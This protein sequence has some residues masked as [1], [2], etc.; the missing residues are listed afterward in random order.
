MKM[1]D[2][3]IFGTGRSSKIV[4]SGLNDSVDIICYLDNDSSKWG[5]LY[6]SK[7]IL[8]PIKITD[9]TYDYIVIASQFN[10][11]IYNQLLELGV[12]K[13]R[14]LQFYKYCATFFNP[15][16]YKLLCLHQN[17]E[18]VE[19]IATGIS[20][21]VVAINDVFLC[22][23][24]INIAN[25]S[26]DLYYD[27]NLIKYIINKYKNNYKKLNYVFIGLSYYSF[28]YD[29]SLSSMKGNALS[30]YKI[31]GEK[32]NFKDADL[33]VEEENNQKNIGNKIFKMDS[34]NIPIFD[35]KCEIPNS[36]MSIN[37]EIGKKQAR[38]DG[39][40]D[41]PKTVKENIKIFIEYLKL[42]KEN[43]IKPIVIVCPV[44]QYYSKCFSQKLKDE[45]YDIVTEVRKNYNFQIIDYFNNELFENDD[46]YDVSHLNDKGAKKFTS[47]LNDIVEW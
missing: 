15:I 35:W 3:I 2:I 9:L 5:S 33:L 19:V 23:K 4:E 22:K 45:F 47:I 8:N 30:Y 46:F 12:S 18:D 25:S 29:M 10:E 36:N 6:N 11:A 1:N 37:E 40:K 38:L 31:I 21:M 14:I 16:E 34:L 41:Y 7:K 43:N 13:S 26:Q 42:L 32:H 17:I 39:N 44:S 24:I 20:Y 28:Q 27:Y